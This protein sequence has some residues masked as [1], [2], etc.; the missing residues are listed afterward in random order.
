MACDR[1]ARGSLRRDALS[2]GIWAALCSAVTW[3]RTRGGSWEHFG[4]H[5]GDNPTSLRTG[6][7]GSGVGIL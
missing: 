2:V 3:G 1:P 7:E 5:F 6:K 4:S